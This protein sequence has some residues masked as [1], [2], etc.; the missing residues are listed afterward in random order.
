MLA[1]FLVLNKNNSVK[2]MTAYCIL[3]LSV[4][5]FIFGND[6][7][8]IISYSKSIDS[9]Y[10]FEF[11]FSKN[12]EI[13]KNFNFENREIVYIIQIELIVLLA[14]CAFLISKKDFIVLFAILSTSIF[15]Y[16]TVFNNLRQ[17]FSCIVLFL[18]FYFSKDKK[19]FLSLLLIIIAQLFHKS[20]IFFIIIL[21]SI[22]LIFDVNNKKKFYIIKDFTKFFLILFPLFAFSLA[23]YFKLFQYIDLPYLGYFLDSRTP[24][25]SRTDI[26]I[27]TFMILLVYLISEII[28]DIEIKIER[29][30]FERVFNELRLYRFIIVNLIIISYI[31]H[32]YD[33]QSRFM[34]F[35]WFLEILMCMNA[36][37]NKKFA[38]FNLTIILSYVFA[39][40]AINQV[41]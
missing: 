15:F 34:F 27:K 9:P 23:L 33:L 30:K 13:L 25:Y 38:F 19:Y 20:S 3:S 29:I 31:F 6:T 35:Y 21:F 14:V 7:Y 12:L 17:G 16:L 41:I 28:I 24:H 37:K 5:I 18:V 22:F 36:I 1:V 10:Q 11:I 40:N 32:L 4:I 26:V 8:D 2:I 39:I